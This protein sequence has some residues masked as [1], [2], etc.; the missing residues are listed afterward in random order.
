[1]TLTD[2]LTVLGASLP[3][4]PDLDDEHQAALRVVVGLYP[5]TWRD[6]DGQVRN[7]WSRNHFTGEISPDPDDGSPLYTTER[8]APSP[9]D[10][11]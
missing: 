3:A 10:T 8:P 5:V 11:E 2:A 1:M 6:N 4:N 7:T 9:G